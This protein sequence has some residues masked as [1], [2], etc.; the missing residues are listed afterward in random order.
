MCKCDI[1]ISRRQQ[2]TR[3]E[4]HSGS[5]LD[6]PRL[7]SRYHVPR[8]SPWLHTRLDLSQTGSPLVPLPSLRKGGESASAGVPRA[9]VPKAGVPRQTARFRHGSQPGQHPRLPSRL[10]LS[11]PGCSTAARSFTPKAFRFTHAKIPKFGPDYNYVSYTTR[12]LETL[13]A[14][15]PDIAFLPVFS[16]FCVWQPQASRKSPAGR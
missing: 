2:Q 4:A 6:I 3:G 7:R 14:G 13:S 16:H 9:D 15:V 1:E 8:D 11:P 10:S 5:P 12:E